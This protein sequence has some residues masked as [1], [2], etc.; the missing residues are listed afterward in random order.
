M[1]S[2]RTALLVTL[3]L[4]LTPLTITIPLTALTSRT[5]TA[6][7]TSAQTTITT[8]SAVLQTYFGSTEGI[9]LVQVPMDIPPRVIGFVAPKGKCSQF[10]LPLT[11][12]PGSILNLKMTSKNPANLYLLPTYTFQTSPNGCSL[13]GAAILTVSNFTAYTMHWS[14]SEN[15]TFYILFTGPTTIIILND[16]GSTQ[17]VKQ[18]ATITYASSTET[19]F[20]KYSSTSTTTYTTTT[21][22]PNSLYLQPPTQPSLEIVGLLIAC[23]GVALIAVLRRRRR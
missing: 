6:Y 15:G 7:T 1:T 22:D 16:Q 17:P 14:A 21:T 10:T 9:A 3:T 5:S 13:V 18:N 23:L 11:V 12:T 20:N 2:K 8:N 4:L 19:N